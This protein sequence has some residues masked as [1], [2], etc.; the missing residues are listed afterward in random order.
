M[1]ELTQ[2]LQLSVLGLLITFA[3]LGL[4]ILVMVVLREMFSVRTTE[5][6]E[7][8]DAQE[9]LAPY[10]DDLRMR[11]AGI[12]VSVASLQRERKHTANLGALLESPPPKS[13][14]QRSHDE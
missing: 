2:G 5:N 12:A 3:S 8:E 11:A 7:P 6:S 10:W 1:S 14:V 4:L 9:D 13:G